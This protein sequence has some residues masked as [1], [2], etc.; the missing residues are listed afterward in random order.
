MYQ[1]NPEGSDNISAQEF[2]SFFIN[3]KGNVD[4]KDFLL[5][6][7]SVKNYFLKLFYI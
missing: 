2:A 5:Q 4:E 7:H 6:N 1:T 3:E